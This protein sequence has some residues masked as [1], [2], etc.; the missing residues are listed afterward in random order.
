M[1]RNPGKRD[2]GKGRKAI[3]ISQMGPGR[4]AQTSAAGPSRQP[5]AGPS[6]ARAVMHGAAPPEQKQS[7][8]PLAR[9]VLDDFMDPFVIQMTNG[10]MNSSSTALAVRM[11]GGSARS[12]RSHGRN[13]HKIWINLG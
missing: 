6:R 13:K 8:I 10:S 5:Q 1:D 9:A 11:S 7:G 3:P 12:I 4:D 2:K